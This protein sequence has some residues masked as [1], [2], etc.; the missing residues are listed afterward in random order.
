ML[1]F[2]YDLLSQPSRALY[3]FLKLNKIPFEGNVIKLGRMEHKKSCFKE[4][5]R[6]QLAPCIVDDGFKLSETVAIFRYLVASNPTVADHWYPKDLQQRAKVDEYLEWQH[7]NTRISCTGFVRVKYMEPLTS[8]S[9]PSP[10]KIAEKQKKMEETL[11]LLENTWLKDQTKDFLASKEISFAD[12][13]AVS[14]LETVKSADYDPFQGRPNLTK[15]HAL[16]REKTNPVYDE[17]HVVA[18]SLVGTLQMS[19][20][21]K[22]W[23]IYFSYNY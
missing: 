8:W 19:R 10:D 9:G 21:K 4:I 13:L 16:V 18:Y 11:D 17:A 7:N 12:L 22:L 15:W 20:V 3:I 2:Y 6:F 5:N 1:Q 14:E 23:K